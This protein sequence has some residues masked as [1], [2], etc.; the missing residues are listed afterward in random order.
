[1]GIL[2]LFFPSSSKKIYHKD[3]K[4]LLRKIPALSDEERAYV[5]RAFS[6]DLEGGLSKFEIQERCKRLM[7]KPDD[8]LEPEEVEK[9][10]E[11]LLRHFS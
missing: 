7:H 3:F 1:M 10:R 2:D 6:G 9:T 4:E 11:K 8:F 5:E